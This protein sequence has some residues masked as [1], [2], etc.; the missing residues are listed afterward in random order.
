[1]KRLIK[2]QPA[3]MI[4]I[5]TEFYHKQYFIY[6]GQYIKITYID[7]ANMKHSICG[8][9]IEYKPKD[10]I[11]M[12]EN[13]ENNKLSAKITDLSTITIKISDNEEREINL[14]DIVDIDY[15]IAGLI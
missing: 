4:T 10:R 7:N 15:L 5:E 11:N 9:I 1:M 8:K 13:K 12:I 6:S 2:S 14:S 3:M